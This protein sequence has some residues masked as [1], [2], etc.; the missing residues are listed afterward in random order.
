[1]SSVPEVRAVREVEV[2]PMTATLLLGD[3]MPELKAS[4]TRSVAPSTV[5]REPRRYSVLSGIVRGLPK[6]MAEEDTTPARQN[7]EDDVELAML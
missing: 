2:T 6:V 4:T 5:D 3:A 1:L 7:P